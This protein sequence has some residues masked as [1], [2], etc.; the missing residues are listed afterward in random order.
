MTNT[1]LDAIAP[2]FFQIAYVV[3]DIAAAEAWFQ[4]ILGVP[5]W[6][7]MEN[8][9]FGADCSYRGRPADYVAHLSLGYVGD[10]QIEL[11][12]SVRGEN[13]YT[14]FLESKGPGLHHIA[15]DVPDFDATMAAFEQNGVE[16]L[17]KGKMGPGSQ[18]AY[19]DCES[20]E[21]SV[22][23]ILGFDEGIRA[24]MEQLKKQSAD[25]LAGR[26]DTA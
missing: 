3:R 11:I 16:L 8:M 15:F 13:L 7:R 6:T 21:T 4:K 23:E 26:I 25:A 17:A 5:A 18:F 20:E 1:A 14:E 10:T 12:E 2:Y 22:I 19:F 24:F 9:A